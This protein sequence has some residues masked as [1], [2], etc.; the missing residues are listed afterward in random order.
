MPAALEVLR[1]RMATI[2]DLVAMRS[3]LSWDQQTVM[4]PKG[5]SGRIAAMRTIGQIAHRMFTDD[6]TGRLLEAAESEMANGA[7]SEIDAALVAVTRYDRDR[8]LRVP[9]SLVSE[10]AEAAGEGYEVWKVARRESDFTRFQPV[11]ERNLQLRVQLAEC[12]GYSDSPY[13][14]LLGIYE[15]D[16]RTEE[17][18]RIFATLVPRLRPLVERVSESRDE[19]P[20]ILRQQYPLQAQH[21]AG[22]EILRMLGYDANS[23]RIDTT[24]HPFASSI[25]LSDIR[26]TTRFDKNDL[27]D[28]LL[29]SIHEFGHG[30]Y[31]AQVDPA[32]DRTPL[33]SGCSMTLHESQ[34]RFWENMIGRSRPFWGLALPVLQRHFPEQLGNAD[35]ETLFRAVNQMQPS[36]IRIES[37]ELTYG[38][39]IILRF[40][41]EVDLIEGR[42]AVSDLP[43]AWNSRMKE[44]LGIDVPS[45]RQGVLQDVHWS[46]GGIGYFPTYLLGSVLSAQIWNRMSEDLPEMEVAIAE[47]SFAAIRDWQREHIHRFGRMYTPV[48]TIERAVGG[49]LDPEPYLDYMEKKVDMLYGSVGAART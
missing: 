38:F 46:E 39:H 18:R 21:E 4:P 28:S 25:G 45:D 41:L 37:D 12:Y 3:L 13:D 43:E 32:L 15:R 34:S 33:A 49:P 26:L 7:S 48:E 2:Y 17:V 16:R 24:V 11:L 36:L 1:E 23:W 42:L 22:L 9:P 10:M 35:S 44:Y 20:G 31:E 40:E 5:A 14:A 30:L 27:A 8:A 47:G 29:S 6:E 19:P